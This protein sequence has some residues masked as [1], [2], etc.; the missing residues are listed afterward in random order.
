MLQAKRL[1]RYLADLTSRDAKGTKSKAI[2]E[3]IATWLIT[4]LPRPHAVDA[5]AVEPAT[6]KATTE[7]LRATL[8][9]LVAQSLSEALSHPK[10]LAKTLS[11]SGSKATRHAATEDSAACN[12]T[13]HAGLKLGEDRH[14]G[15]SSR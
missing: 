11:N 7:P 3:T 15:E 8:T 10:S 1:G 9:S 6:I 4:E 13:R 2:A 5:A 14:T 12:A